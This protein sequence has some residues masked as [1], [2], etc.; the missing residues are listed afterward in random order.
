VTILLKSCFVQ[1]KEGIR[2][3]VPLKVMLPPMNFHDLFH[4]FQHLLLILLAAAEHGT[5]MAAVIMFP[6]QPARFTADGRVRIVK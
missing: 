5:D 4:Y 3:K 2:K 1:V 6:L